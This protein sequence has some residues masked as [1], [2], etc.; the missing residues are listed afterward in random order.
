[1]KSSG[2]AKFNVL[3]PNEPKY[4]VTGADSQIVTIQM[5]AGETVYSEPGTML[6]MSGTVSVGTECGGCMN[7]CCSGESC[8]TLV[9]ENKADRA[10]IGL[11][12]NF[13]SKV[14]NGVE[15]LRGAS[16]SRCGGA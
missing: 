11:T 1:M 6:Y 3:Y 9:Y 5:T 10:F 15:V 8:C 12:P 7:R 14:S 16:Y 4:S 2:W 13:P